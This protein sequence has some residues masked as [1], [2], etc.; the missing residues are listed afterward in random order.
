MIPDSTSSVTSA[1]ARAVIRVVAG[2]AAPSPIVVPSMAR[3]GPPEAG[4]TRWQVAWQMAS[5]RRPVDGRRV[6]GNQWLVVGFGVAE[7]GPP[8]R[9]TPREKRASCGLAK[10]QPTGT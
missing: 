4:A 2:R 5:D 6:Q 8:P 1:Q 3:I 9:R 7:T 10:A